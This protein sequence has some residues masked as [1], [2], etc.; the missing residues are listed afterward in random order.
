MN[1]FTKEELEGMLNCI[2]HGSWIYK[3][4]KKTVINKLQSMIDN[5]CEHEEKETIQTFLSGTRFSNQCK[6]CKRIC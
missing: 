2:Y 5:Y 3:A 1:D 6:K 4:D